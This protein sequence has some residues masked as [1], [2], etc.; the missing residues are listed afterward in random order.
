MRYHLNQTGVER[1]PVSARSRKPGIIGL[2]LLVPTLGVACGGGGSPT[3]ASIGTP[4]GVG[5]AGTL[6]FA[7]YRNCMEQAGVN[8][9]A[10]GSPIGAL[11]ANFSQAVSKCAPLAPVVNAG[12]EPPPSNILAEMLQYT[13]CMRAHGVDVPDP[14]IENGAAVINVPASVHN[15]PAYETANQT[16]V[17][18]LPSTPQPAP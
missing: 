5:S 14:Q 10:H 2:A 1:A 4:A 18:Q 3:V 8:V 9:D 11:P 12:A 15:S 6:N 17:R 13:R 7:P 16:C